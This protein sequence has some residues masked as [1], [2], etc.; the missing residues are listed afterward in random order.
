MPTGSG[1]P[2]PV[3]KDLTV[4]HLIRRVTYG[5]APGLYEEVKK[6]GIDAWL[7]Q[8]LDPQS[9]PD[10]AGDTIAKWYPILLRSQPE[11]V[12]AAN[13]NTKDT[14]KQFFGGLFEQF[15]A[16]AVW[17]SRQLQE[18]MVNFWTNHL[19]VYTGDK[20]SL[21]RYDYDQMIRSHALGTFRDLLVGSSES[22]DMLRYLD[23]THSTKDKPNQNYA[24]ELLELHTVGVDGGY[25]EADVQQAS[26]F[27]TGWTAN[28][29]T[30]FVPTW[31]PKVH[32]VGPIKIMDFQSANATAEGG[33]AEIRKY[34]DYLA[35][36]PSTAKRLAR[37]LVI[38]FVSDDPDAA[39]VDQLAKVYLDNDTAIV[40]VLKALFAS[41]LFAS[42]TGA[43]KIR[44]PFERL[45]ATL[46]VLAP[47]LPA[48]PSGMDDLLKL[49]VSEKPFGMTTPDG[50]PDVALAWTAPGIALELLNATLSL[51]DGLPARL[52]LPGPTGLL[53][54][55]PTEAG[56]LVDALA[57]RL[58]LRPSTDAE[59]K[60][61]LAL[62][63]GAKLGPTFTA[64]SEQQKNAITTVAT[65]LLCTP[66]HLTR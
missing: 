52:G 18:V 23:S 37:K 22:T 30:G 32:Y 1:T 44:R 40:P 64:G 25:T 17:S 9:L 5:P 61:G 27:L 62:L 45:V 39:L 57:Q 4:E 65:L 63:A 41:P 20:H 21:T 46:R 10:P 26:L 15:T 51:T 6:I 31:K 59:H 38:R 58:L 16:R 24:R 47:E 12:K 42:A 8:Q 14:R 33:A 29:D 48:G 60:A 49:V 36:H 43:S 34:L 3:P 56:A 7:G 66:S 54:D 13:T 28:A 2:V 35:T 19:N 50:Y 11:L 55:P 53:T